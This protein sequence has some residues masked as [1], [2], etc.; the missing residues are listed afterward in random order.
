MAH[1]LRYVAL[2]GMPGVEDVQQA[3][4]AQGRAGPDAVVV[5]LTVAARG[6]RVRELGP[7]HQI[8]GAQVPPGGAQSLR[9]VQR[10]IGWCQAKQVVHAVVV[11]RDNVSDRC[12][13][14]EAAEELCSATFGLRSDRCAHCGGSLQPRSA[15]PAGGDGS[16]ADWARP[17]RATHGPPW[18]D[19]LLSPK[20][21]LRRGRTDG[22]GPS[23]ADRWT[24]SPASPW[25]IA[26]AGMGTWGQM[27][28]R[29]SWARRAGPA[30]YGPV[31]WPGVRAAAPS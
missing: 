30:P 19:R 12:S 16:D 5:G 27:G 18:A 2:Q 25:C 28:T 23:A 3:A 17:P 7:V 29:W 24:R 31:R 1:R 8:G 9:K 4:G 21:V 10:A 6:Q 15:R 26:A 22:S 14:G 13:I 20:A 11:K